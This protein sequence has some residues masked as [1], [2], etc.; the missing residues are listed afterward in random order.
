MDARLPNSST[1]LYKLSSPTCIT[2]S[3]TPLAL[4]DFRSNSPWP[5]ISASVNKEEMN[6]I[7]VA[8]FA[9]S[10]KEIIIEMGIA[11]FTH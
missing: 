4:K 10:E 6:C 3:A 1:L 8:V 9:H 5:N 7:S 11:A 2:N